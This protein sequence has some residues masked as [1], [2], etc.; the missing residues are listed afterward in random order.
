[1]KILFDHSNPFLLAHGGFQTQIEESKRALS[2]HGVDVEF[3]R[4]W[5]DRQTGDLI[6]FFGRPSGA[7]I[8]LAHQQGL[9]V[10]ISELL[11]GLGSRS[12]TA[13]RFQTGIIHTIRRLL[14]YS[15]WSKMAWDAYAK[16]DCCIALTNWEAELMQRVFG[17]PKDKVAIVTNGVTNEFLQSVELPRG[18]W[19]ICTATIT[20]RKRVLETALAAVEAK[21]PLWIIGR[22]YSETEAYAQQFFAVARQNPDIIRYEGSIQDRS[23]LAQAYQ[24]ARGFV[25][26][27]LQESLSLSALEAAACGCPSLLS[28]LPWA[29]KTFGKAVTYCPVTGVLATAKALRNFYNKAPESGPPPRPASWR[30]IGGRLKMLYEK[31]LSTS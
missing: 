11:T 15:F 30:E 1:M 26:L 3:L 6:H 18:E 7:Y 25:L 29:R 22:P 16:A 8:D 5:D 19:L 9:R 17:A 23:Q 31:V 4:W 14:P 2:D 21:T 10:V 28:D 20:A 13:I 27:S 12:S 24:K